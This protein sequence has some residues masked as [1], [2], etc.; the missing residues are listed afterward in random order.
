MISKKLAAMA[1]IA[2]VCSAT[3]VH[4]ESG[5]DKDTTKWNGFRTSFGLNARIDADNREDDNKNGWG[6][7]KQDKDTMNEKRSYD[8]GVLGTVT[9]KSSTTIT[10]KA[11]KDGT[12]YTVATADAKIRTPGKGEATLADIVVGDTVLV[13]GDIDGTSIDAS[14]IIDARLPKG[15]VIKKDMSGI[16]GTVTAV[17]GTTITV[18]GKNDVTYTVDADQARIR[19]EGDDEA[20]VSDIAV[21]DTVIVQGAVNSTSVDATAIIAV[22]ADTKAELKAD[23]KAEGKTGFFHKIGLFFKGFFG[24]KE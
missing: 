24:K 10:V 21:G 3:A 13:Q 23:L 11:G 19:H 22:D 18:K 9:A 1:L 15:T 5:T 12:L 8:P 14:M 17:T 20:T 4:A 2:L 16:A 7:R 6:D